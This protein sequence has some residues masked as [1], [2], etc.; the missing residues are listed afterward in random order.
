MGPENF[1]QALGDDLFFAGLEHAG[2]WFIAIGTPA[3]AI[4]NR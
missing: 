3:A 1:D 4:R 2:A